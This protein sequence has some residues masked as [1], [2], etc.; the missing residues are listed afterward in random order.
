MFSI[1][2]KEKSYICEND[3]GIL[4]KK[5]N[6]NKLNIVRMEIPSF[7]EMQQTLILHNKATIINEQLENC[8]FC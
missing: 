6:F 8:G 3:H 7:E 5:D 4:S 2:I 1:L